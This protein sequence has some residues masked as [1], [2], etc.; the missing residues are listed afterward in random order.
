MIWAGEELLL[1]GMGNSLVTELQEHP[2]IAFGAAGASNLRVKSAALI[3]VQSKR[4]QSLLTDCS[5]H[6]LQL[7]DTSSHPPELSCQPAA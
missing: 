5:K 6:C 7:S 2:E 1:G 3:I 4:P